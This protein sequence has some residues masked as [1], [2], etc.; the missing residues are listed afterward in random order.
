MQSPKISVALCTYN[1]SKY[2][3]PQLLSILGQSYPPHEIIISDDD[4]SD[5]TV[6]LAQSICLEAGFPVRILRNNSNK[7]IKA[8]FGK[9]IG[10]CTGD[11]I[12]LAD[13]DDVWMPEKLSIFSNAILESDR[14]IPGLFY[15]NLNLIDSE[16][17]SLTGSFFT[18]ARIVPPR[19]SSWKFLATRNFAPGC[20]IVFDSRLVKYILP[21]PSQS[22]LHDWWVNLVFSLCGKIHQVNA[23]TISY[24]L[25]SGN[26][27]GIPNFNRALSA[28]RESGFFSVAC[29]NLVAGINQVKCVVHRLKENDQPCPPELEALINLF[30][31]PRLARPV[32]LIRLGIR[33]GNFFKTCTMLVASIFVSVDLMQDDTVTFV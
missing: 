17:R 24:R 21:I 4:S 1:G 5:D 16:G 31:L 20:C 14:S 9:A 7:G 29:S 27:Q 19:E 32:R 30:E 6:D 11:Y 28:G 25:H 13:Q 26:N 3:E 15:S 12:A 33:R 2:L 22:I 10:A 18:N 23:D 8:N